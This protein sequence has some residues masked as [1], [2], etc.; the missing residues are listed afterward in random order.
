MVV[1]AARKV[2]VARM[3]SVAVGAFSGDTGESD[4]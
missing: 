2:K 4:Q 1:R 3:V